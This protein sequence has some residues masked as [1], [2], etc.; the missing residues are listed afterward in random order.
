MLNHNGHVLN[1]APAFIKGTIQTSKSHIV[2]LCLLADMPRSRDSSDCTKDRKRGN[3]CV[4]TPEH[5]MV[6]R[7]DLG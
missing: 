7:P 6:Y 1:K 3:K 5:D 2:L 4:F